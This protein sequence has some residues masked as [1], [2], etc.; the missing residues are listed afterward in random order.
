MFH[1]HWW[2]YVFGDFNKYYECRCGKRK[3]VRGVGG[4]QP[5]DTKWLEEEK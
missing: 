1:I 2:K 4:Y 5:I 3:V